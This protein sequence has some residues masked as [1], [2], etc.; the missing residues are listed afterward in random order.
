MLSVGAGAAL[1]LLVGGTSVFFIYSNLS[2]KTA[3]LDET[4]KKL[5]E[6]TEGLDQSVEKVAS[7]VEK[8]TKNEEDS[9]FSRYS[10][11]VYFVEI[12]MDKGATIGTAFAIDK[13]GKL[14]TNAHIT[15]PAANALKAGRKVSVIAQGGKKVY[16]VVSAVSHPQYINWPGGKIRYQTPDVGVLVVR[17]PP[18][19]LLPKA[20]ELANEEDLH[21]LRPG[22]QLCYIGFPGWSN[23]DS[24]K[25]IEPH[26]YNGGL[27][28]L[29]TLKEESGD[30][31]TTF[32]L[33]HDMAS[34]G[35]ASGSPIFNRHGKVVAIHNSG[36]TV[37][38]SGPQGTFQDI[39]VGPKN[40]MRIDLLNV[41]LN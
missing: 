12:M 24:L 1:L 22:A 34:M 40:G 9:I 29:M 14:G 16:P 28:R 8:L 32:L 26:I 5:Q 18:G 37:T 4:A 30:F 10:D 2:A 33:Q 39:P 15:F 35:G 41:L 11:A 6:K 27:S 36:R 31:A 25:R 19:E 20:V 17:L 23:Y 3:N 7:S 21:K 38:T 13:N